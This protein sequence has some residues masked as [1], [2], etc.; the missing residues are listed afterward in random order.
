M[1]VLHL[2]KPVISGVV[3]RLAE[4]QIASL[5]LASAICSVVLTALFIKIATAKGWVVV[6]SQN[7]WSK[8]TVA[9]F[10][11]GPLLLIFWVF[12]LMSPASHQY[13][14]LLLSTVALA[15]L[16]LIDDIKG[17][18]PKPKLLAEIVIAACAVSSGII[19]PIT[20]SFA[21]NWILTVLWIVIISN[22]FNI[23]DNMDGLA[24]GV[25]II[26]LAGIAFLSGFN[27][28]IGTLSV[29][30]MVSV[31]GFFLFNFNPAKIFMGDLGSLPIGFFLASASVM[32]AGR[33]SVPLAAV[34]IPCLLLFV[35]V[36][37]MFLVS[38]TRRLNGRAISDGGRDHSSHRLVFSGLSERR[39][40][41]LLHAMAACAVIL[42][43]VWT[44]V[45]SKWA[46]VVLATSL[47]GVFHFWWYLARVN[48]PDGWFSKVLVSPVPDFL[49][50]RGARMAKMARD[51][52]LIVLG[53]YIIALLFPEKFELLSATR[54][55]IAAGAAALLQLGSFCIGGMYRA[56]SMRS[57][58]KELFDVL[59]GMALAALFVF[60]CCYI[61]GFSF[62]W[63]IPLLAAN[64]LLTTAMLLSSRLLNVG[65]GRVS[66]Q[67]HLRKMPDG[68]LPS[69]TMARIHAMRSSENG[70]SHLTVSHE[71]ADE[72][73]LS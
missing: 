11:G 25:A 43:A 40:V 32:T 42:A 39:A 7:R 66:A 35:P 73:E 18:G 65:L 2:F 33:I 17:L 46:N 37:D 14:V 22:A 59:K 41:G 8:R 38:L 62:E 21:V 48:L 4:S 13:R 54:L 68:L 71:L 15:L 53:I 27:S 45:G 52:A 72:A 67:L 9:Q 57:S 3:E 64:T 51:F 6:P 60:S 26:S 58:T 12:A 34:V 44:R 36:F 63:I 1:A 50:L 24:G 28:P 19:S 69:Q 49:R 29:V 16:G 5:I 30:L 70:Y 23:I 55:S 10:G 61:A 31:A 56:Q 47:I 20:P